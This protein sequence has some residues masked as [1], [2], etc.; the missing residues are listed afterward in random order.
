[1]SAR[2]LADLERTRANALQLGKVVEADYARARVRV[3]VAGLASAWLPWLAVRAGG[4]RTWAAPEVG[5]QVLIGCPDG[6]PARGVVLGAVFQQDHAA[7]ADS[8][9]LTRSVYADG[10]VF[11]YDREQHAGTI[12]LPAGGTLTITA[13]GGV[14]ITGDLSITGALATTGTV[15][16]GTV[17]LGTHVHAATQPGTGTS[18]APLP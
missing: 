8:A 4:D 13:P 11:E 15:R 7:P 2:A 10:A 6:D 16:S 18:G 12:T 9:D 5:E 14:T 3:Q 1:M 17:V